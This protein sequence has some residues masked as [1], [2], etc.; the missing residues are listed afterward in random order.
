MKKHIVLLL[1]SIVSLISFAQNN[2]VTMEG[3]S[4]GWLDYEA[5]IRLKNN[6][7]ENIENVSFVLTY[8]DMNG[9]MLDYKEFVVDVDIAPDM[10]KAV[11]I[12]AFERD[13]R[14]SYYKSEAM[15]S[16]PYKFDVKFELKGYNMD[17][18]SSNVEV[19]EFYT[20]HHRDFGT[21][22]GLIV[23]GYLILVIVILVIGIAINIIPAVMAKRRGRNPIL[24]FLLGLIATPI[25]AIILLLVL[26][27]DTSG[28]EHY[29]R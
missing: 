21:A 17:S 14:A 22:A 25:L 4:Q 6:T 23:G 18:S 2:G 11:D 5:T 13:R 3:F 19:D 26:G 9:T 24:W 15:S 27:N 8:Y 12:E 20:K 28:E 16:T 10:T 1:L 7:K 29:M